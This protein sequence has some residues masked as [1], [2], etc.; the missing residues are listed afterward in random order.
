MRIYNAIAQFQA[1]GLVTVVCQS[2]PSWCDLRV[3]G[4]CNPDG[5]TARWACFLRHTGCSWIV[6][7]PPHYVPGPGPEFEV[8]SLE[9]AVAL[10]IFFFEHRHEIR[11][12]DGFETEAL[13]SKL[14]RQFQNAN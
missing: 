6:S 5:I 11:N 4:E 10:V 8:E 12:E 14:F 2:P 9:A 3:L 13:A 1:A 7:T